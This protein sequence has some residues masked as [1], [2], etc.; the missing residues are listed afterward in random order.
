MEAVVPVVLGVIVFIALTTAGCEALFFI[1]A[2]KLHTAYTK[3]GFGEE[4]SAFSRAYGATAPKTFR[5]G[6]EGS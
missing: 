3:T 5:A 2:R 4:W 1:A 6:G